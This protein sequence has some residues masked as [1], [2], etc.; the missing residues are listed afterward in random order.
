MVLPLFSVSQCGSDLRVGVWKKS[1][2]SDAQWCLLLCVHLAVFSNIAFSDKKLTMLCML[3]TNCPNQSHLNK[4]EIISIIALFQEQTFLTLLF[5]LEKLATLFMCNRII[6]CAFASCD[7]FYLKLCKARALQGNLWQLGQGNCFLVYDRM[8]EEKKNRGLWYAFL[9]AFPKQSE[10]NV[11]QL[12]ELI[13]LTFQ[14]A[15]EQAS[16]LCPV[17]WTQQNWYCS[18]LCAILYFVLFSLAVS[19][20]CAECF[21]PN[22]FVL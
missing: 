22:V 18:V 15:T 9:I 13:C 11:L 19:L 12:P 6:H 17:S 4:R 8:M 2:L 10:N 5:L 14:L 7:F 3:E 16:I 20:E 1:F 21:L